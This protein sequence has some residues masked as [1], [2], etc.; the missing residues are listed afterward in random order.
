MW[1]KLPVSKASKCRFSHPHAASRSTFVV[2]VFLLVASSHAIAQEP[3]TPIAPT[4]SPHEISQQIL[5][6]ALHDAVW[7]Q[8]TL[9][10]VRQSI[11][12]RGQQM[13]GFGKYVR[14]GQGTGKMRLSLQLP[15]G[16]Q[17]NSLLQISD[18]ELLVTQESIGSVSKRSRVDLGKIRERLD[19]NTDSWH[20]PVIAM[21]LAI[22]GQAEALRKLCQQYEWVKV[23]EGTLGNE[24][25]WW[26][27]GKLASQPPAIRALSEVDVNLFIP[28]Q[29]A[30]LPTDAIVAIGQRDAS[31]PFWLFQ[32]EQFRS[33]DQVTQLG[34]QAQLSVATEWANPTRLTV[35]QLSADLFE[36]ELANEHF[37]E[38]TKS[39][40]PP[41]PAIAQSPPP[42][43]V[44]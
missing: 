15:A 19:I 17:M 6:L 38:E 39:Y 4:R 5:Y 44:R 35:P 32:V 33:Q 1:S 28:N 22:G 42:A 12:L 29:S 34:Y 31:M 16:D 40:L 36:S 43:V 23:E 20:D 21:Y 26:L 11:H 37:V 18:G 24:P 30:L 25:V 14:G 41:T 9:C 27:T 3:I 13:T 8:P 2:V 7:G 10:D